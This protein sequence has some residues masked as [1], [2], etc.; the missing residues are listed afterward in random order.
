MEQLNTDDAEGVSLLPVLLHPKSRGE[1]RL[2]STDPK[3]HPIIDPCFL[4]DPTDLEVLVKVNVHDCFL[5]NR[6]F[7]LVLTLIR[8]KKQ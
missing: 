2:R 4:E 1:I 8:K 7:S 5:S 3:E 6:D